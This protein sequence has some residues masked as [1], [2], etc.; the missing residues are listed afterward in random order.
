MPH[1]FE[2]RVDPWGRLHA[3]SRRTAT[4]MGNRGRLHNEQQEIFRQSASKAWL[5]CSLS[6]NGIH[7][8]IFQVSPKFS[9]SELFFLDEATA[10]AAGHRPCKDCQPYRLNEFKRA[11][12][13]AHC[14]DRIP[15][16]LLIS[17]VD[18]RLHADRKNPRPTI[19]VSALPVGAMFAHEGSAFL[20]TSGGYFRWSLDG[21]TLEPLPPTNV[22]LLTP[23]STV[24]VLRAGYVP[25]IHQSADA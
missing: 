25:A 20:I 5:C 17:E 6:L 23:M 21:Y 11:W 4:R 9:Y 8:T 24:Q 2:N 16:Q 7:R 10:L 22:E 14:P 19:P 18:E 12:C 3:D 15:R 1:P 13:Q